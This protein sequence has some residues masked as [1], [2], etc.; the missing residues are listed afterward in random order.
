MHK[1]FTEIT[2]IFGT[3]SLWHVV[4]L[5]VHQHQK[6]CAIIQKPLRGEKNHFSY[7]KESN[8][9]ILKCKANVL[10]SKICKNVYKIIKDEISQQLHMISCTLFV[11]VFVSVLSVQNSYNS[12]VGHLSRF[13]IVN[14]YK[15]II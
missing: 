8:L 11:Y 12:K 5:D 9:R 4:C 13:H 10:Y 3:Q 7:T 15:L 14:K 1:I 6:L 2:L